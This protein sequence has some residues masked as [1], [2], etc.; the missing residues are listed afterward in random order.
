MGHN[1]I[2]AK[3]K[4]GT[5]QCPGKEIG[6]TLHQKLNSTPK[7][8]ITKINISKWNVWQ[9][10][11]K[12]RANINRIE[13]KRKTERISKTQCWFLEKNINMIDE[14]IFKLLK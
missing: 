1:E 7:S 2:S 4:I 3:K 12:R 6:E 5:I 14:F 11:V 9:E 8:P 10:T 13:T